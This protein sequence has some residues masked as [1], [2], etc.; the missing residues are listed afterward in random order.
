[1]SFTTS[2]SFPLSLLLFHF[3]WFQENIAAF[4]GLENS[5]TFSVGEGQSYRENC[6]DGGRKKQDFIKCFPRKLS[7]SCLFRNLFSFSVFRSWST[8][9]TFLLNNVEIRRANFMSIHVATYS[10]FFCLLSLV[11]LFVWYNTQ[12]PL[13]VVPN[14]PTEFR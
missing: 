2:L 9:S 13:F 5:I 10:C 1:M 14:K 11:R 7:Q 6:L 3:L 12:F 4:C 8:S